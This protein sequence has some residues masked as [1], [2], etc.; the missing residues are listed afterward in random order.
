MA[1]Q[2]E[3]DADTWEPPRY[4]FPEE[5]LLQSLLA[6]YFDHVNTFYPLLH[7]PTFRRSVEDGLHFRDSHFGEELLLVCAT[8]SRHSNDPRVFLEGS[9]SQLSCGWKWFSQ[10]QV[11]RHRS[12]FA[13]PTLHVL[14]LYCVGP[15]Y[16]SVSHPIYPT[17]SSFQAC[18]CPARQLLNLHG[19]WLV[20]VSVTHK[21]L[22]FTARTRRGTS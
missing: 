19:H 9:N 21:S 6:T 18:F 17:R 12:M 13:K 3:R 4:R 22:G 1:S 7:E 16:S 10:V 20:W 15:S 8:A 5:D 14:Q 11:L 2:W